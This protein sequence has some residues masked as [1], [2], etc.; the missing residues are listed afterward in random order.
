MH[1]QEAAVDV[2]VVIVN[3]N[4][5]EFLLQALRSLQHA[6]RGLDVETWVVDNN[7]IDDS[8][9]AVREQFPDVHVIA[10]RENA[11]FGRANNQ[12]IRQAKGEFIFILN[13]DT[14]VQEDT[15]AHFV[16]FMRKH[17]DCGAAGCRILNPDGTFAPESRR[18]FPTPSTAFYRMT[19]L[20]R[21]FP[22]SPR[23]GRYNMTFIPETETCEVDALSGSCMMVRRR[24]L[25]HAGLFDEAF[26]MY[27]EDLDLCFRIQQAG[28]T[29]R[30]TPGTQIIH[31]KGESTKKGEVRYVK[32]FY[33]AMLLF[34]EKHLEQG[35][36]QRRMRLLTGLLRLGILMRA[37]LTLCSNV[38]RRLRRPLVDATVVATTT[39]VLGSIRFLGPD[40]AFAPRFYATVV[41]GAALASVAGMALLGAYRRSAQWTVR[42]VMLGTTTGFLLLGTLSFFI[43]SIAYSRWVIGLALPSSIMALLAIHAWTSARRRRSRRALVV[44]GVGEAM[45]LTG[46]LKRHPSPPFHVEGYVC[47][48]VSGS[49]TESARE[50]DRASSPAGTP[51]AGSPPLLGSPSQLRDLVRL[52]SLS[53]IVFAAQDV[54]NQVIFTHMR[55]L[56]DLSV[57]FRMFSEGQEHVVGKST[58]A[59]VSVA[60]LLQQLKA[61]EEPRSPAMRHA[62][63]RL[64]ALAAL[65]TSPIVWPVSRAMSPD[66]VT[67]RLMD[68]LPELV[69]VARGR[70]AL[71][72]SAPEHAHL[73]PSSWAIRPGMF[74][75]MKP[76]SNTGEA[77]ELTPDEIRKAYWFYSMHQSLA[78]DLDIVA[79]SLR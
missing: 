76:E 49:S 61:V 42:A 17:P 45:R 19:G 28:W 5:R 27:G 11:G 21:L 30:Y 29:I 63:H 71:V 2:S 18:S 33:G 67:R 46:L 52:R 60:S 59:H 20:A 4:V 26:F 74:P 38:V 40:I 69:T 44:G 13:P 47:P 6:M 64:L 50:A 43:Q 65:V 24:A 68:R 66:S 22:K 34:I 16:A 55:E 8:V 1:Q 12:A 36:H 37:T 78:T 53:D 14:I 7:S 32:L 75:V 73:L 31:Y 70:L 72:G 41:P 79:V 57:Q 56:N 15:L 23:F 3:Y 25:D 62:T 51:G 10:N 58:I 48:E 77:E 9:A 54:P 35:A 39:G